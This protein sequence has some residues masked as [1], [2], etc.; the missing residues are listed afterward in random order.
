VAAIEAFYK[1]VDISKSLRPSSTLP[2]GV[3]AG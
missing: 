3:T 1:D 2:R